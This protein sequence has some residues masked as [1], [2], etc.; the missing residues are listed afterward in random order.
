MLWAWSLEFTDQ[1]LKRQSPIFKPSIT[2]FFFLLKEATVFGQVH[3]MK[4]AS[5]VVLVLK[6]PPANAED[7]KE[8]LVRSLGEED[9]LEE[10]MET[11]SSIHA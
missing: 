1:G 2:S 3:T 11:H 10:G 5:Q 7:S 4:G 9:P 8:W 6:N